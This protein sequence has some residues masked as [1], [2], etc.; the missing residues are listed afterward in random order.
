MIPYTHFKARKSKSKKNFV[1]LH[2]FGGGQGDFIF[3]ISKLREFGNVYLLSLPGHDKNLLIKEETNKIE[4]INLYFFPNNL[5]NITFIA[6][7][8]SSVFFNESFFDKNQTSIDKVFLISPVSFS[9]FVANLKDISNALSPLMR[10]IEN[11]IQEFPSYER[12]EN[13]NNGKFMHFYKHLF[14]DFLA[15]YE[16]N[17]YKKNNKI[18]IIWGSE[19]ELIQPNSPKIVDLFLE[20]CNHNCHIQSPSNI[21]NFINKN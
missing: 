7:S 20:G 11:N 1:L 5:R 8:I 19:D 18:K 3:Y 2:G 4:D 14:A 9:S 16:R 6:H 17:N 13:I 10:R 12:L 15:H 21:I